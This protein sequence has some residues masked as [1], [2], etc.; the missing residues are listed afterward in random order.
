MASHLRKGLLEASFRVDE[1]IRVKF[2]FE[3]TAPKRGLKLGPGK[4]G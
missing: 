1:Q 3:E 4:Y 2:R